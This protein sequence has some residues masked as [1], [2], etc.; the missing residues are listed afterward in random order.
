M[1]DARSYQFGPVLTDRI[2]S[3][4]KRVD[5]MP[6]QAGLTRIPTRFEDV[7]QPGMMLKRGTYT[8]SWAIG[9]TAAVTLVNTTQT[10]AV[11]NY[12]VDA[13]RAGNTSAPYTVVFAA[14]QGTQTAVEVQADGIFKVGTFSGSWAIGATKAVSLDTG[15]EVTASNSFWPIPTDSS[16]GSRSCAVARDGQSWYLVVPRLFSGDAATSVTVTSSQIEFGTLPF[17]ALSDQGTATFAIS[18]ATCATATSSP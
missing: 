3:V 18:I 16:G 14:I 8:G 7:P 15:G 6:Y 1:A 13:I 4:V 9:T 12:C 10:I 11:T 2:I 5:S 17:A